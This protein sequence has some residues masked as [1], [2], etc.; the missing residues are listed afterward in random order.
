MR[1]AEK[2]RIEN[3]E[4]EYFQ[5]VVDKEKAARPFWRQNQH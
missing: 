4:R 2:D 5:L 1:D 3:Q